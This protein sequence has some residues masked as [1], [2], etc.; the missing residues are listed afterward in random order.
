MEL[1]IDHLSYS[2]VSKYSN[3]GESY[4]RQYIAKEPHLSSPQLAFGSAFH[5]VSEG[6]IKGISKDPVAEWIA[7]WEEAQQ[8]EAILW[9][10]TTPEEQQD[11]GIAMFSS[12]EVLDMLRSLE[13]EMIEVE[14][15][16]ENH[17]ITRTIE[18]AVEQAISFNLPGIPLPIIGYI[19]VLCN[20]GVPLDL[21]T[22]AR[23]WPADKAA[24]ETQ[25]MFY[26]HG[27]NV[28]GDTRHQ[29]RF[30]HVV[31]TKSKNP[32]VSFYETTR[33]QKD[34]DYMLRKVSMAYAGITAGIFPMND[35]SWFCGPK[36][37]DF[38]QTCRRGMPV[39]D[40]AILPTEMNFGW[41]D[42]YE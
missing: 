11:L 19:D 9:D 20:D 23:S 3:C 31:I 25:P 21:K 18:A 14:Y 22:A 29:G 38:Y 12:A 8:K 15:E 37:C 33:D 26:L 34:I 10:E 28:K 5:T 30:R 32:K 16:D 39:A 2:A 17:N 7:A 1:D 27:L 36:Y 41:E 4:R 24:K 42:K 13:P 6:I 35:D 40:Q